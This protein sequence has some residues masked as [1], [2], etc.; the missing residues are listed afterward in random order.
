MILKGNRP[1]QSKIPLIQSWP[2]PKTVRDISSFISF[3]LFYSDY[4]PFFEFRIQCLRKLT[5]FPYE[6]ILTNVDFDHEAQ[7]E[8]QDIKK[9]LLSDPLL[10][11]VD[12][13]KRVYLRTDF[14]SKGF[15]FVGFTTRRL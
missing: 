2:Q 7:K 4:I 14:S 5:T 3:A 11:R 10:R 8:W 6:R 13:N 12:K 1:A 9:A 15:G